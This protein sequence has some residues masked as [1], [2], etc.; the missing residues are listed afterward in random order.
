M[1]RDAD[2]FVLD[3]EGGDGSGPLIGE[4]DG[5]GMAATQS[6][7]FEFKDVAAIVG[8]PGNLRV[9]SAQRPAL[10]LSALLLNVCGVLESAVDW[11][12]RR[13]CQTRFA[14]P[15]ESVEWVREATSG[16]LTA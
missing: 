16:L 11:P 10:R 3:V 13:S 6:H 4:R 9:V 8:W 7:A 12:G 5:H 15:T 2:W 1:R 14:A